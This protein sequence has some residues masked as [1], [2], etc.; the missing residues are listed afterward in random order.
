M[1]KIRLLLVV[2]L[3]FF[4][5]LAFSESN[6]PTPTPSKTIAK[7]KT[8]A[9]Q[10]QQYS[11]EDKRGTKD[12]SAIIEITKSPT[13][14][15]EATDKTEKQNDYA[16]AEWGMVYITFALFLVTATLA[17]YTARLW[18]ITKKLK[19]GADDTAK[20]QLRAYLGISGIVI[21]SKNITAL[22]RVIENNAE[23]SR[24]DII[25]FNIKNYGA[26]PANKVR[27]TTKPLVYTYGMRPINNYNWGAE[28]DIMRNKNERIIIDGSGMIPTPCI[29][30]GGIYE[31][32]SY[33]SNELVTFY[34]KK[35]YFVYLR[36][37]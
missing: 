8:N 18:S 36:D 9:S 30:P 10:N 37:Y 2:T 1:L 34:S 4:S 35:I 14:R 23:I 5:G 28:I 17:F 6:P 15:V 13:I 16:S 27:L 7:P 32:D 11:Q 26:T 29:F 24:E 25:T 22:D 20:R 33:M 12:F 19:E 31:A 3:L 21:N